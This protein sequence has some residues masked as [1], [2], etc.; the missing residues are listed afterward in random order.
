MTSYTRRQPQRELH[1]VEAAHYTRSG[2]AL[3]ATGEAVIGA[4]L[5]LD[6][7]G[8]LGLWTL[9]LTSGAFGGM[10][11]LFVYQDGNFPIFH[12]TAELL[13][14]IVAV[15]SGIGL[16]GRQHWAQGLA[17]VTFGM[18]GYSAINSA[19]WP[20]RNDASLLVPMVATL[21]LVLISIP[22]ILRGLATRSS[23]L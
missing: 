3:R 22:F 10:A 9:S 13:M 11:G 18:L 15:A 4:L 17:L 5:A 21:M 23:D 6:G 12:L 1:S 20:I 8:V 7:I 2:A 19:G 16:L 14:G